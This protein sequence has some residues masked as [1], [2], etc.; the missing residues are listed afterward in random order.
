MSPTHEPK[1]QTIYLSPKPICIDESTDS[2]KDSLQLL[3]DKQAFVRH[4]IKHYA[5]QI[6][7][8][9]LVQIG[10]LSEAPSTA[11]FKAMR[12]MCLLL[13]ATTQLSFT[14]HS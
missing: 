6:D 7:L 13:K 8:K 4:K 1:S 10:S 2:T 5:A 9:T 11:Y 12:S 3:K 14:K